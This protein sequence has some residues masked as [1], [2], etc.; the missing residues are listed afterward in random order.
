[1]PL[2][3]NSSLAHLMNNF[4]Q[5]GTVAWIGIR[6][7]RR[8]EVLN[9]KEVEAIAGIGLS[10]DHYKG[11]NG[12]RQITLIQYEHLPVIASILNLEHIQPELLRRNIAVKG[13]NLLSMKDKKFQIGEAIIEMTGLCHPCSRMEETL[14]AGGYNAMRGHGGITAKILQSGIIRVGDTISEVK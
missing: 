2:N 5:K 7:E 8:S 4:A 11:K 12:L 9:L 6:P 3:Q 14:G 10:G 1:M 13:I